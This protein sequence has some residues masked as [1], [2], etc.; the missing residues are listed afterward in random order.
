MWCP[1]VLYISDSFL[2]CW[3]YLCA[4]NYLIK[5]FS[6]PFS[7]YL[8]SFFIIVVCLNFL[9]CFLETEFLCVT[10]RFGCPETF[11][12]DHAGL[13]LTAIHLLLLPEC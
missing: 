13:Q 2:Q 8:V 9:F 12:V 10:N 1:H 5:L 3:P 4:H 6:Y 7:D 11:F